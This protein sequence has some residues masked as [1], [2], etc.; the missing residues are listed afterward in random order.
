MPRP[1]L[2]GADKK[3][4][5]LTLKQLASYDDI[6]TDALVD[7]VS[8]P[9]PARPRVALRQR[10]TDICLPQ[11]FYWTTIP[12]NRPS[13]HPS[14]GIK[15]NEVTRIIQ[16]HLVVTP[17]VVVAEAKLLGLDGLKRY[18][19][20]LAT[21]KEKDDFKAHLR[22]YM[23][24]YLPDC[25]FE[26]NATNRY[27]I[28]TQEASITAR[29]LIQRNHPIRYLVGTQVVITPEEEADMTLKKKDFSMVVSSRR[30]NTSLFMGP[31]RF[32]NHDCN[33]N[34]RLVTKGQSAIEVIACRDIEVGEEITVTYGENYFGE[35]NC[36][37]LCQT[38]ETRLVNGW[39][40]VY[41]QP[42]IAGS[43]EDSPSAEGY[44][45]RR[46]R[47][48][49]TCDVSRSSSVTPTMRPRVPKCQKTLA[50]QL[51][52]LASIPAPFTTIAPVVGV[53]RKRR[54]NPE[55]ETETETTWTPPITPFAKQA[56]QGHY[57]I[58]SPPV[59]TTAS[60]ECSNSDAGHSPLASETSSASA[61]VTDATS[62]E[63]VCAEPE[64]LSPVP[65]LVDQEPR[66]L[67]QEPEVNSI[68]VDQIP[69]VETTAGSIIID[70][71][72]VLPTIECVSP[73]NMASSE[74]DMMAT[75][76][77]GA[78]MLAGPKTNEA[79]G[80]SAV[81]TADASDTSLSGL[82]ESP[83]SAVVALE[84]DAL[85]LDDSDEKSITTAAQSSAD[86]KGLARLTHH[87]QRKPGDYTLTPVLL[88]EPNSA[89]IYC[90]NC[91]TAFVQP[92]AYYTKSSCPRCERHSKLY[93]YAWPKTQSSGR[94]DKEE[95]VLDHR[96]VHR[97]LDPED[98]ARAR[99]RLY[100]KDALAMKEPKASI[101]KAGKSSTVASEDGYTQSKFES[102]VKP[103]PGHAKEEQ[104]ARRRS[105]RS[106]RPSSKLVTA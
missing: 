101:S 21:Q 86:R 46:R 12:K 69:E 72:C 88:A 39:A 76:L 97:F 53:G 67:K 82:Q 93:G 78:P 19:N 106:R 95:R 74:A 105:G 13:Y 54:R 81:Q 52:N 26:V 90:M 3:P 18:C 62:P 22:R 8:P 91:N 35:D 10:S 41:G 102:L 48:E 17:D 65:S 1:S 32:A 14:R 57:K 44:S 11:T 9:P 5:R 87:K 4:Q 34:A 36:E 20:Q 96:T 77:T 58:H 61:V 63:S 49:S 29:C 6:L 43:V 27:T 28:V 16:S 71:P 85:M 80:A 33:A 50:R 89:W 24:I 104:D 47:R 38:C 84:A 7:H 40:P 25:P 79:E 99:G 55:T 37:C 100:W 73:A 94:G 51:S 92:N 64:T 68:S 103:T 75:S 59:G 70:T 15:E 98:E 45:L 66:A 56:K 23:A 83:H 60:S 42:H 2:L 30:K 31:A